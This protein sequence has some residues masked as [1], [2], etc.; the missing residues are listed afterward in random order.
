V[1]LSELL[2]LRA[3]P[4]AGVY[5]AITKRCPLSCAHCSTASS[6]QS[7]EHNGDLFLRFA[8]SFD[9]NGPD[10][11]LITGGEPLIRPKLVRDLAE[12]CHRTDAKVQLISGM[13]FARAA[14][15]PRQVDDAVA[16]VDLFT[17]SLDVF[18]EREVSRADVFRVLHQLLDRGQDV[19]FQLT[20]TGPS[21]PY[22]LDLIR[23][24]RNEFSDAVPML[25]TEVAPLGRA[26]EWLETSTDIQEHGQLAPIA[27]CS[28]ATWPVVT[29]DGTIVACCNEDAVNGPRPDHLMVGHAAR[30]DW[31]FVR[32]QLT[33]SH[34]LR[35]VRLYGP[36][37]VAQRAGVEAKRCSGY[38]ESC[39]ALADG[40]DIEI[41][42]SRDF[43]RP[44][45]QLMES[46]LQELYRRAGPRKLVERLGTPEFADLIEL[47]QIREPVAAKA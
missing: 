3:I 24:I 21:D 36:R 29:F 33:E 27:P 22:L 30:D 25:V 18:H 7:E 47:G 38:C 41:E 1:H 2:G 10:V 42:L 34:I 35:A 9:A 13:F 39:F 15:M 12:I 45:T 5:L 46:H 43:G 26:R 4:G 6:M 20:G 28:L 31:A 17:A 19:S 32:N 23:D 16:R 37:R 8:R 40:N 44:T 14:R 11:V